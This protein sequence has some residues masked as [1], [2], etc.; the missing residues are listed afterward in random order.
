MMKASMMMTN[1]IVVVVTIID[2][3]LSTIIAR[4]YQGIPKK[5]DNVLASDAQSNY[6]IASEA[7]QS[8]RA[9]GEFV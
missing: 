5:E 6:V 4:I 2:D 3:E 1:P 7:W 8:R 9:H